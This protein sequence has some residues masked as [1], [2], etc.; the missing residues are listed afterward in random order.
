MTSRPRSQWDHEAPKHIPTTVSGLQSDAK[1][2]ASGG[3]SVGFT[4]GEFWS[5]AYSDLMDNGSRGILAEFLVA[6]ALS[7]NLNT[8]SFWDSYDLQMPS[9]TRIE[10]KASGY[11][12]AWAQR[13]LSRISFGGLRARFWNPETGVYSDQKTF[14]ADIYVMCKQCAVT[15]DE[16]D[17]LSIDQWQFYVVPSKY[18]I[19][20]N[21]DSIGE[22]TLISD[23]HKSVQFDQLYEQIRLVESLISS[24]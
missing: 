6:Q 7:L 18:L 17:P 21:Q 10:V 13:E 23:G 20:K 9:G 3:E 24:A 4:V 1:F 14:N 11:L 16:Y 5:W 19:D 12:Q 2:R 15:H 22:G 8:K